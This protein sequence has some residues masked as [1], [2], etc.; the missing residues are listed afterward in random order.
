MKARSAFFLFLKGLVAIV[1][2][3]AVRP[4]GI[5]AK[6]LY[7]Q[8]GYGIYPRP[9]AELSAS[10]DVRD[11]RLVH[12]A[13]QGS[14]AGLWP[15]YEMKYKSGTKT[16]W[17]DIDRYQYIGSIQGIQYDAK[18]G[19]AYTI[20][21]TKK[22]GAYLFASEYATQRLLG[23]S[24][25]PAAKK[26]Y[27]GLYHF[28]HQNIALFH[29]DDPSIVGQD[30]QPGSVY[31]FCGGYKFD[32]YGGAENKDL[33]RRLH[34]VRWDYRSPKTAEI[35]RSWQLFGSGYANNNINPCLTPD[36]KF[37]IA[38]CHRLS[39]GVMVIG[40]WSVEKVLSVSDE[41]LDLSAVD[42]SGRPVF[43]ERL[44]ESP[45]GK[46]KIAAQCLVTDGKYLYA[47]SSGTSGRALHRIKVMTLDGRLVF[48]RPVSPE[49]EE[50]HGLPANRYEGE[51][52]AFLPVDGEPHLHLAVYYK[53][54]GKSDDVNRVLMYDL[55]N[56]SSKILRHG[57]RGKWR[58]G[59]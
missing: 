29:P 6:A 19:I 49:G 8:E 23:H 7:F 41:Y 2:L 55:D 22:D 12:L 50:L 58:R 36:G 30:E 11:R 35:K 32:S 14:F 56:P 1:V 40:I 13:S 3:V 53:S 10:S 24:C 45:W 31:F 51:V 28:G 18:S 59:Y 33:Y 27:N 57:A 52:L 4:D 54:T 25:D 17:K 34:L 20:R 15:A 48:D 16:S 5:C 46:E 38:K 39:D 21:A 37:L 44:F 26:P 9:S 43:A 47:L 42:S